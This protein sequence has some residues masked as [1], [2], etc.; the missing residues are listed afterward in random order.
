M[1]Y[2][3]ISSTLFFFRNHAEHN[4]HNKIYC[5]YGSFYMERIA[6]WGNAFNRFYE[7]YCRMDDGCLCKKVCRYVLDPYIRLTVSSFFYKRLF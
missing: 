6:Q 2:A 1:Y 7:K 5:P 4:R 3:I